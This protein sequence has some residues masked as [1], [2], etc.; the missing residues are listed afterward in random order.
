MVFEA[1]AGYTENF[2]EMELINDN[3]LLITN[4][5]PLVSVMQDTAISQAERASLFHASMARALLQQARVIRSGHE[6]D[7]VC[8]CGGVFQNRLLTQQVIALLEADGFRV[9]LPELIPVND[10]GISFGQIIE[11]AGLA[12]RRDSQP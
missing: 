9:R 7:T 11:Y 8:L 12:A 1:L 3:N 5:S 6:V 10:A 4:W 2:V